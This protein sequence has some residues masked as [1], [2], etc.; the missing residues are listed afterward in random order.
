MRLASNDIYPALCAPPIHYGTA[1][2]LSSR[3]LRSHPLRN[4]NTCARVPSLPA[5]P[6]DVRNR[7]LRP[8]VDTAVEVYSHVA[9]ELLP[10]PA[11]SH[12][13]F[14][15]RDVSSVFGGMLAIRPPQCGADPR[16]TLTRLWLHEHMRVYHDRWGAARDM[17]RQ[18]I[19]GVRGVVGP[20]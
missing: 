5:R 12:Y 1:L 3:R 17:L 6:P 13:A 8:L 10:T 18:R 7:L 9:A 11:K 14:S 2:H 20:A 16:G 19:C 4:P 15:L